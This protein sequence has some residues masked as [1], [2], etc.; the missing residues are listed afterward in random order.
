MSHDV[1]PAD[2][3]MWP[4]RSTFA[5]IARLASHAGLQVVL[6]VDLLQYPPRNS[7]CSDEHRTEQNERRGFVRKSQ[8]I[9][10]RPSDATEKAKIV[11]TRVMRTIKLL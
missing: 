10:N 3:N 11:R 7:V 4:H 2:D 8:L 9:L 1:F 6:A 5:A